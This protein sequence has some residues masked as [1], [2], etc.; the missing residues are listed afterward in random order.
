[1][2]L[3]FI[4]NPNAGSGKAIEYMEQIKN[5]LD[6]LDIPY[7]VFAASSKE[8]GVSIANKLISEK[9]RALISVGGDGT[10]SQLLPL[11]VEK[12]IAY[13]II[14]AGEGNDFASCVGI[15]DNPIEAIEQILRYN[16]KDIDYVEVDI[17]NLE[18]KTL[19]TRPMCCF[20]CAGMEGI[21]KKPSRKNQEVMHV[22]KF[23]YFG[24]LV[25]LLFG[26][27]RYHFFVTINGE[28]KEYKNSQITVMNGS[29]IA[30][31][32]TL[33]PL[34]DMGDGYMDVVIIK[35]APICE[36]LKMF[37]GINRGNSEFLESKYVEH[38]QVKELRIELVNHNYMDIDAEVYRGRI[39][40]LKI[41]EKGL[42]V[43]V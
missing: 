5:H 43:F 20:L 28:R 32:L 19:I 7:S 21:I 13:G 3:N 27:K 9:H 17:K 10:V 12:N 38:Y 26:S 25:R 41:K 34:A 23:S 37:R 29:A 30:S 40:D 18:G 33:C 11:I 2:N 6:K 24:T 8:E 14:P 4:L 36:T 1:M 39:I 15:S 31:G 42:K 35:D 16:I 22:Q